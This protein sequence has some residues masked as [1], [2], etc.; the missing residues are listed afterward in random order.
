M[1]KP[2]HILKE[3][4]RQ[5]L[6]LGFDSIK[7][8]LTYRNKKCVLIVISHRILFQYAEPVQQ[9][10]EA[11][12]LIKVKYCFNTYNKEGEEDVQKLA[13]SLKG[14][15]IPHSVAKL[16]QW[17]LII[18]PDHGK[19]FR[20]ECP[21]FRIEHGVYSGKTVDGK[22]YFF[23]DTS[24]D[25]DNNVRYDKLLVSSKFVKKIGL[26]I[27]EKFKGRIKVVG[28]ILADDF[29]ESC[30]ELPSLPESF[31]HDKDKKTIMFT[32]TWGGISLWQNCGKQLLEHLPTLS[33]RYNCI[34]SAHVLNFTNS[35]EDAALWDS[36]AKKYENSNVYLVEYGADPLKLMAHCDLVISDMTSLALYFPLKER[37]IIYF[38]I[39]NERLSKKGLIHQLKKAAYCIHDFATIEQDIENAITDF[40]PTKIKKLVKRSFSKKNRAREC[41]LKESYRTLKLGDNGKELPIKT[42]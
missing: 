35:A 13:G 8:G 2:I 32:S 18:F 4:A 10:L 28:N 1:V 15:L 31:Q 38:D 37:P 6:F 11:N 30:E 42:I 22:S 7:R 12:P 5:L 25:D 34:V 16:Y 3:A 20:K 40:D 17:D 26:S 14:K 9:L 24:F 36:A 21:K 27:S 29:I 33:E 41:F 39:P 19:F 23:G